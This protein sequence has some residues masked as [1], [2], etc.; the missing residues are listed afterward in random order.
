MYCTH[1]TLPRHNALNRACVPDV[2]DPNEFARSHH[3]APLLAASDTPWLYVAGFNVILEGLRL[4]QYMQFHPGLRVY[5]SL[6]GRSFVFLKDFLAYFMYLITGLAFG[7]NAL[8]V[9]SG[10]NA[11]FLTTSGAIAGILRLTF[12]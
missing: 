2:L 7:C 6:I 4:Q 8:A 12:G 9:A 10:G 1:C 11:D 3:L 5:A